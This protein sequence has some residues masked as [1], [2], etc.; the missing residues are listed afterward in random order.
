MLMSK[1]PRIEFDVSSA[2][3]LGARARQEDALAIAFPDGASHGFA[4]LSDGMGGHASGDL[5]SRTI[6]SEVFSG[7]TLGKLD[8]PALVPD[9]LIRATTN[10]N[11][12][13]KSCVDAA[14]DREG[15][16]GT[17]VAVV[18]TEDSLH[19]VS[20]G[21][22]VLY[23]FRNEVLQRL[24]EDHSM[25]PEIDLMLERGMLTEDQAAKH[26]QRNCLT[27]ALMGEKIAAIDCP[28]CPL[29]LLPEDVLIVCS[30]GLQFLP[31]PIIEALLLRARRE[32]SRDIGQDLMD[33]LQTMNDPEQDNTAIIVVQVKEAR[34]RQRYSSIRSTSA[35]IRKAFRRAAPPP[36]NLSVRR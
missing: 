32:S 33:A 22:S 17:V 10:A 12:R 2:L 24:N 1:A 27:A 21:D 26:P 4:V 28:D 16:G 19:W 3:S 8:D 34:Q 5:A 31:D 36:A 7:L 30:D 11:S 14:P 23:L 20:V 18:A 29:K 9:Q 25:A 13:L 15:M 35:A 6:V